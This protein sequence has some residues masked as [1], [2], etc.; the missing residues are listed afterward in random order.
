MNIQKTEGNLQPKQRGKL[1]LTP[2]INAQPFVKALV[3][4]HPDAT[5]VK[6]CELFAHQTGNGVSRTAMCRY[7]QQ[8]GL[9][10]K[11]NIV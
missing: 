5:G 9:N 10:R 7:L 11:K 3:A 4:E 1:Q 2:L 8:L 6:L